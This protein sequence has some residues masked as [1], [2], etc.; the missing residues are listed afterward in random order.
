MV[1]TGG[2]FTALFYPHY[3]QFLPFIIVLPRRLPSKQSHS[4]RPHECLAR[5]ATETGG[6]GHVQRWTLVQFRLAQTFLSK[7]GWMALMKSFYIVFK[8][9]S[10]GFHGDLTVA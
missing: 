7:W 9:D 8:G 5:I 3:V 6:S 1:M 4:C 2:W 10:R